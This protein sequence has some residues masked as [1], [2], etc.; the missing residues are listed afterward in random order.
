MPKLTR[1][2]EKRNDLFGT[3]NLTSL[4]CV[5]SSGK[6]VVS[7]TAVAFSRTSK[8]LTKNGDAS[9]IISAS[10]NILIITLPPQVI[11]PVPAAQIEKTILEQLLGLVSSASSSRVGLPSM[12]STVRRPHSPPHPLLSCSTMYT[13]CAST[14]PPKG[15]A[16][17]LSQ[18]IYPTLFSRELYMGKGLDEVFKFLFDTSESCDLVNLDENHVDKL[19]YM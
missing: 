9:F 17:R 5:N 12:S 13:T 7:S 16:L 19:I 14:P 11:V 15:G 2:L 1:N 8:T 4:G 10:F 18:Q 6:A 3:F